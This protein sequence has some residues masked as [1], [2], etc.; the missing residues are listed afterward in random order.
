[1]ASTPHDEPFRYDVEGK[2]KR[3]DCKF[4]GFMFVVFLLVVR[5]VLR[6]GGNF[7][8][9]TFLVYFLNLMPDRSDR[10]M[11]MQGGDSLLSDERGK[12]GYCLC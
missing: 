8:Q 3:G 1:M 5:G 9:S 2:L 6:W 10:V 4:S 7:C 12:H 11:L